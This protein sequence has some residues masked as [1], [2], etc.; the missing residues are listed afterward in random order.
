MAAP[1][2]LLKIIAPHALEAALSGIQ[3]PLVFTNGVFDIL[4]RGHVTLTKQG[5]WAQV[6]SSLLTAMHPSS[7]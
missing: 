1:N 6:W 5:N 2:Y 4:H 7:V 3:R